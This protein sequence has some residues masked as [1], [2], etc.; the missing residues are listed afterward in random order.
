MPVTTRAVASKAQVNADLTHSQDETASTST[1]NKK[2][3]QKRISKKGSKQSQVQSKTSC[4]ELEVNLLS[5]KSS[6]AS[7]AV[8]T[9]ADIC[10]QSH[11]VLV[12]QEIDAA[13]QPCTSPKTTPISHSTSPSKDDDNHSIISSKL[14]DNDEHDFMHVPITGGDITTGLSTRGGKM[15]F[16]N[17]FAYSYMGMS[18]KTTGWRCA[19][20]KENCKAVIHISKETGKIQEW[21]GVYHCH[22]PDQREDRER[23]ILNKIKQRV[24]DENR[25]IKMIIEEEYR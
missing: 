2:A 13:I 24:L 5:E 6:T 7:G 22:Q 19:R 3:K 21:N 11:E 8:L 9:L 10:E 4:A 20:R 23:E 18:K 17:G 15:V 25:S 14:L 12:Q 1:K 16:I